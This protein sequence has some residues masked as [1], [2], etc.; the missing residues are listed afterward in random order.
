MSKRKILE[1]IGCEIREETE[2]IIRFISPFSKMMFVYDYTTKEL[3]LVGS[4][5]CGDFSELEWWDDLGEDILKIVE[6]LREV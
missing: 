4:S 2:N 3:K 6:Y 5:H 1:N